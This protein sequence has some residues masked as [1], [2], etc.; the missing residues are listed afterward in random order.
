MSNPMNPKLG[1]A[2]RLHEAGSFAQAAMLYRELLRTEPRDADALH[3]L[4]V[5]MHQIG[6][7][8]MAIE[9][10][11]C[12]LQI[13]PHSGVYHNN[14]GNALLAAG[15]IEEAAVSYRAAIECAPEQPDGYI[16]LGNLYVSQKQFV[17]GIRFYEQ[18]V[19]R[20]P[21]DR[22]AAMLLGIACLQ[23]GEASAALDAFMRVVQ[24]APQH[25]ASHL[26]HGHA[27]VKCGQLSS[28]VRSF[29]QAV[30]LDPNSEEAH[31]CLGSA[32]D[33]LGMYQ[34]A[35]DAF[36]AAHL[37]RPDSVEYLMNLGLNMT[38]RKRKDGIELLDRALELDPAHVQA[39][40]TL[41]QILLT[42]GN[43]SRGW[44][45]YEWR[46]RSSEFANGIRSF[47]QPTWNGEPLNGKVIL[48]YAEQGYG[49]TIQ[50]SRYV[51]QVV[52]LGGKVVLEVQPLLYRLLKDLPGVTICLRQGIDPLP[53]FDLHCPL[54]SVPHRIQTEGDCIPSPVALP[55]IRRREGFATN[56]QSMKIGLVWAGNPAH[57]RDALRSIPLR[58]LL[59]LREISRLT[60]VSLQKKIPHCDADVV[61]DFL[62]EQ[63]LLVCNDFLDTAE[64]IAG[65]DLVIT[66]DTAV[67]H[68]AASIGM[69]VWMMLPEAADW[70]WG[71]EGETT[72]WY[73]TMRLFR[74]TAE[75]GWECV[76]RRIYER[77]NHLV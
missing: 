32:F 59:P 51:Q 37:L 64:A 63:P 9:L 55:S 4:G 11:R 49:D 40:I 36:F 44:N 10:I 14:L 62:M 60:F 7:P 33:A 43:Y 68:L 50:F 52:S 57:K 66:V 30:R 28:A 48:L 46:W 74:M 29:E 31:N 6:Q 45:E 38:R 12:A 16:N 69:P 23:H 26:L 76:V 42:L 1:I 17:S 72:A 65:L 41:A 22:D 58:T 61:S 47:V 67:A 73:P 18:A 70:R 15:L 2:I 39:H 35:G 27:L 24:L 8:Q 71:L 20:A 53:Y 34:K 25:A 77:L 5:L 3:L 19:A 54:M 75:E 13:H 21:S 56:S